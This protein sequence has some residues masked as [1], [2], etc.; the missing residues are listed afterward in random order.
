MIISPGGGSGGGSK[1]LTVISWVAWWG[2]WHFLGTTM[3]LGSSLMG[4]SLSGTGPR[5]FSISRLLT[6]TPVWPFTVTTSS[7]FSYLVRNVFMSVALI[8][9]PDTDRL[10]DDSECRTLLWCWW[11]LEECCSVKPRAVAVAVVIAAAAVLTPAA[12]ACAAS[13][14]KFNDRDSF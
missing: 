2:V 7:P 5:K 13:W 10:L 8:I 4:Y 3:G 9:A 12:A 1:Y 14:A 6:S 11:W